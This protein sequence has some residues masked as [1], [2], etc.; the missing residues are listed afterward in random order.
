MAIWREIEDGGF[1]RERF[2]DPL[3]EYTNTGGVHFEDN[4]ALQGL[5]LPEWSHLSAGDAEKYTEALE[6]LVLKA[7]KNRKSVKDE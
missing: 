3:L 4:V 6:P 7:L 1:P 2:W 5:E